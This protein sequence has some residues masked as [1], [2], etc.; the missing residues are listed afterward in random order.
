MSPVSTGK[1]GRGGDETYAVHCSTEDI[2]SPKDHFEFVVGHRGDAGHELV[3]R[4]K[5]NRHGG[6]VEPLLNRSNSAMGGNLPLIEHHRLAPGSVSVY[7]RANEGEL[8]AQR[9]AIQ[10]PGRERNFGLGQGSGE[11]VRHTLP[12][13]K[14]KCTLKLSSF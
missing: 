1:K 11:V 6:G 8:R 7:L 13:R 4:T 14:K 5:Q 12:A 2:E 9:A 10:Y 3:L